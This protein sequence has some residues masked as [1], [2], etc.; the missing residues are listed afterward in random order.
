MLREKSRRQN[1]GERLE[2]IERILFFSTRLGGKTANENWQEEG[3]PHGVIS[4]GKQFGPRKK[5]SERKFAGVISTITPVRGK[6]ERK[7]GAK[8][9]LS[10]QCNDK[11][12]LKL[13]GSGFYLFPPAHPR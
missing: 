4:G 9:V 12:E 7:K 8:T 6:G 10:V 13:I 3:C 11:P 1:T 5:E 2:F